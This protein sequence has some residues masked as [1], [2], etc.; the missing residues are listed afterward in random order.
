MGQF[1]LI[2]WFGNTARVYRIRQEC[3][4]SNDCS[5]PV[6]IVIDCR[7]RGQSKY[8]RL[9]MGYADTE[10]E[11]ITTLHG[12]FST[13]VRMTWSC[14]RYAHAFGPWLLLGAIHE[15]IG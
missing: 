4:C 8:A 13:V 6:P 15:L 12:A 11:E 2:S 9:T 7:G 3:A 10:T 5:E 14:F 1:M